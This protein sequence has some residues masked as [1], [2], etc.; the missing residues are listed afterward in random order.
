MAKLP[1]D[2]TERE[3]VRQHELRQYTAGLCLPTNRLPSSAG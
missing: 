2:V 3:A 1:Q